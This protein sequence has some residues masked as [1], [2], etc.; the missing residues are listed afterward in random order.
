ML[1]GDVGVTDYADL[2]VDAADMAVRR[3]WRRHGVAPARHMIARRVTRILDPDR[4]GSTPALAWST[5]CATVALV[6]AAAVTAISFA[7]PIGSKSRDLMAR[8]APANM[9]ALSHSQPPVPTRPSQSDVRNPRP[10]NIAQADVAEGLRVSPTLA[11][12]S[13][14]MTEDRGDRSVS[15]WDESSNSQRRGQGNSYGAAMERG[16]ANMIRGADGMDRG[17]AEM[18]RDAAALRDPRV[19]ERRIAEW[20][21]RGQM[22]THQELIDAIPGM[23]S[24]ARAMIDGA[25][26][27][28]RQAS[29]WR[30]DSS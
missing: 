13:L 24:S 22:I 27:M 30:D 11:R 20:A 23:E 15:S 12:S 29:G 6:L 14:P 5:L 9:G 25:A 28:R 21:S 4:N 18:L 3:C 19:R 8:P 26:N 10:A 7:N 2:L 16:A 1:G 17:A